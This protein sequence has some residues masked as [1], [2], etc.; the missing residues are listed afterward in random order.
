MSGVFFFS[1]WSQSEVCASYQA[2]P[3]F[4]AN[5][6]Q[7]QEEGKKGKL[8]YS[9]QSERWGFDAGRL[10]VHVLNRLYETLAVI[11]MNIHHWNSIYVWWK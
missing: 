9:E 1:V 6:I 4:L 7:I 10:H 5:I 8:E 2:C 3:T 11:N